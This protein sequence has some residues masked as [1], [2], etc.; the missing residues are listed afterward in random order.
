M[1]YTRFPLSYSVNN[2][3]FVSLL[4]NLR[5]EILYR[6]MKPEF[7]PIIFFIQVRRSYGLLN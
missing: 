1:A 2:S 4:E 7:M 5:K 6:K 3:V